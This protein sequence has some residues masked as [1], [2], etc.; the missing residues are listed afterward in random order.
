MAI[1][2]KDEI[3]KTVGIGTENVKI[4]AGYKLTELGIIP[5]DWEVVLFSDLLE[6]RN[7]VNADKMAYGKGIP[8]I[9]ILEIITHTHLSIAKVPGRITLSRSVANLYSV[10]YGDIFFNRTSETQEE[11]GLASTYISKSNEKIVFGGFVI[12]GRLRGNRIDAKY[13]GYAFRAPLIRSQIVSRGQGAIRANIGQYDLS[14][15]STIIPSLKEQQAIAVSLSD[16]DS[17][18]IY[19]DQLIAKKRDIKQA[20]MQQLLTGKQR[21]PG[22]TGDWDKKRLGDIAFCYSGG[23]PSTSN[24]NYYNGDV[25]WITSGDLNQRYIKKVKGRIT[26]LGLNNSSAQLVKKDSLLIALYGATAGVTAITK[27]NAAINQAILA[28]IPKNDH[29]YFLFH[30]F[31]LRKNWLINTYTQGGQPNLSG[32][33]VKAIEL[34]IPAIKEQ[35]AIANILSDMDDEITSLEQQL[36]KTQNLK[37]GMMQELLTGRIRLK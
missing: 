33:I 14:Q 18:I 2:A 24:L 25:S 20:A 11:L 30:Y 35:T 10:Q 6:F 9:N 3:K 37:Q 12:R 1:T 21:L 34:Y 17:L 31:E 19:L 28:V 15:V 16:I 36:D 32:D 8:F 13:S 29:V 5:K 7:G 4:P 23:T 26:E 22:F 27:I